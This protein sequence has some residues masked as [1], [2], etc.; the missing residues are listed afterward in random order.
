MKCN[1]GDDI[2]HSKAPVQHFLYGANLI[3]E[4]VGNE[5]TLRAHN[6]DCFS[7]GKIDGLVKSR[8]YTYLSFR[9]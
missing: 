7:A 8:F 5:N 4:V 6:R 9:A 2:L 1:L 3:S